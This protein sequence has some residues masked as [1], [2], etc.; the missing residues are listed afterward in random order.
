MIKNLIGRK[1]SNILIVKNQRHFTMFLELVLFV[2]KAFNLAKFGRSLNFFLK[3]GI[4]YSPAKATISTARHAAVTA[5]QR[6]SEMG[7]FFF[8]SFL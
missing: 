4:N 6:K 5:A 2:P 1:K 3:P 8:V 7:Q